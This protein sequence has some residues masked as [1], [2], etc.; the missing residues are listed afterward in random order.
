M[1]L[2]KMIKSGFFAGI[3]AALVLLAFQPQPGWGIK[4]LPPIKMARW[5]MPEFTNQHPDA[6]VNSHPLRVADLRGKVVLI[7]V[8]TTS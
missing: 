5:P 3:L 1:S 8:W 6:W 4:I 7:K 2:R